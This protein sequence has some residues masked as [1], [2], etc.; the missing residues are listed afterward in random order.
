[1]TLA[2]N[3]TYPQQGHILFADRQVDPSTGTIRI[4]A[5]FKNPGNILRPGQFGRIRAMT[6]I[7]NRAL[8]IP[9]RAVTELQGRYQVAVVGS[10]NKVS[11]HS[12]EVGSRV[13]DLWIITKGLKAGDR[14]VSEGT[15]K[16]RDGAPVKPT[17]EKQPAETARAFQPSGR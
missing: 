15:S 10:D 11:I 13:G 3:S 8:V 5:A 7:Q 6:T 17:E 16:V 14:V 4:V 9:Q 2:N 1:L 12:V